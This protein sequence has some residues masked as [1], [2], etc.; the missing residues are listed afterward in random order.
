MTTI[1]LAPRAVASPAW[2][3]LSTPGLLRLML[4]GTWALSAVF[5]LTASVGLERHR[6]AMQTIGKD[7]APSII[8]AER[9]RTSLAWAHADAALGL[10]G[11]GTAAAAYDAHRRDAADELVSAAENITYG[12]AERL[13]IRRLVDGFGRYGAAVARARAAEHPTPASLVEAEHILHAELL[14]DADALEWANRQALD[15]GYSEERLG[16]RR[17]TA[18]VVV[19]GLALLAALV[20]T[21]LFL[22]RRMRR[23][24]NPPLVVAS[25]MTAAMV[26]WLLSAMLASAEDLRVAKADA[27]DSISA[28]SQ[29]RAVAVDVYATRL[30]GVDPG[31]AD[32]EAVRLA[33]P[34]AGMTLESALAAVDAGAVPDGFAGFLPDELRNITFPGEREAAAN[35]LRAYV[36]Q[37]AAPTDP[38]VFA[39]FNDALARTLDINQVAFD[40]SVGRGFAAV[41]GLWMWAAAASAGVALAAY[42]GLR[43]RLR[44]YAA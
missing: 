44:E 22:A 19:A 16:A 39:G 34:P 25:A 1:N 29:A 31:R 8:A 27:F 12:D 15:A 30:A 5:L 6:H 4:G 2:P 40:A 23:L 26:V 38:A 36:A 9:I 41:G 37:R 10:A 33:S 35:A 32:A 18:A 28:L 42:L 24:V 7:S 21:Q 11:D 13:P 3:R 17:G 43:P 20:G 14:P